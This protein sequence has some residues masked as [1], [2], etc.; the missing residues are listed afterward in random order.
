MRRPSNGLL[1]LG[2]I[3]IGD[4]RK[5]LA[6]LPA[7][8]I[9]TIITSPPYFKLRDYGHPDQLGL[10]VDV[11]GWVTNLISVCEELARVLKPTGSLW[12]NVGDGYSNHLN[13]GAT[14]KSLLLG[15][16]RLAIALEAAG[17]II[18]NQVIWAKSNPM[19]SSVRDRLS[20][21]HEVVLLCVRSPRYF[22]D[23][24]PIR[25]PAITMQKKRAKA[26][27]YQYLP[28]DVA[29]AG[30][31]IDLTKGSTSSKPKAK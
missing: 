29:P 26:L 4:V 13:Q 25:Q 20:A 22:F 9:D 6:D 17:W 15:P 1:P 16:Q 7:A 2:Q 14:K 31:D 3:L 28:D 11:N 18:R 8:S 24:D 12:L 21:S 10:E 23:L 27:G 5:R 30:V 19:P